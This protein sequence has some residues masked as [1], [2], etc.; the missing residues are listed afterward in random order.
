MIAGDTSAGVGQLKRERERE[1]E[2]RLW[3]KLPEGEISLSFL[4]GS[5]TGGD[6][7]VQWGERGVGLPV[8]IT[9]PSVFR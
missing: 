8:E 5:I 7:G 9:G 4:P 1:G 6:T 3:L 2:R